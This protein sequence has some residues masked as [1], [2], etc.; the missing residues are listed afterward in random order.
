QKT[1]T[2]EELDR[3]VS[4]AATLQKTAAAA[5]SRY[6]LLQAGT[7]PER[8][9]QAR[10]KLAQLETQIAELKVFAPTNCVLETLQVRVGDVLPPNR[11][12]ATLLLPHLWVRVYVP[13]PWLGQIK[14]NE[15]VK[16]KVD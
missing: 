2:P 3:A 13:E 15:S 5:K 14:L 6:D 8:I 16:V 12:I 7:R 10:A 9:E 11:E 4:R 1:I